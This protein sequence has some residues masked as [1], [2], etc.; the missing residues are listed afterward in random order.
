[1]KSFSNV[2]CVASCTIFLAACCG[3]AKEQQLRLIG[4]SFDLSTGMTTQRSSPSVA[5]N[6]TNNEFMVAWFDTRNPGNNDIFGQRISSA[7]ALLGA[8]FPIIEFADAQTDP[9]VVHNSVD[10]EY[11]VGWKTQQPGF[12]NDVQWVHMLPGQGLGRVELVKVKQNKM[13]CLNN[14]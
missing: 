7:G 10:N 1:M 4:S 9:I 5:Y 8:N 6:S 2:F 14:T 11:L 3:L 13:F 12:F